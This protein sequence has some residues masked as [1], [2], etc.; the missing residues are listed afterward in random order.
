VT[1]RGSREPVLASVCATTL[2][3]CCCTHLYSVVC[4]GRWR[5]ECSG[6]PLGA[7]DVV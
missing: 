2:A 3:A 1:N 7:L 4:S 6:T 5:A